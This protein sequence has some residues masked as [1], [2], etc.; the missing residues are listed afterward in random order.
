MQSNAF[1]NEPDAELDALLSAPNRLEVPEDESALLRRQLDAFRRQLSERPEQQRSLLDVAREVLANPIFRPA[2]AVALLVALVFAGIT[3]MRLGTHDA[4]A[5]VVQQLRSPQ[6]LSYTVVVAEG[7]EV[8]ITYAAPG[9]VRIETSWGVEIIQNRSEG[10]GT[11]LLH[12][13]KS[14][15]VGPASGDDAEVVDFLDELRTLPEKATERLGEQTIGGRPAIGYKVDKGQY[16]LVVWID[17]E[18]EQPLQFDI[19]V[20]AHDGAPV[21]AMHIEDIR[22][23]DPIDPAMFDASIPADY[24]EISAMDDAPDT[25]AIR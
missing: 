9:L 6:T 7:T 5:N 19:A 12:F 2:I 4:Y 24:K 13:L 8:S 25:G 16:A 17:S 22:I 18:T 3:L 10:T 21:H 11:I 23:D 15:M 1:S 20:S 14:Y